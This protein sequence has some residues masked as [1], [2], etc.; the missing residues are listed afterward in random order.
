MVSPASSDRTAPMWSRMSF[1][2]KGFWPIARRPVKPLPTPITTRSG[3]TMSTNVAIADAVT[4]G[5][6]SD[7]ISTPGPSVMRDVRAP[8]SA[9]VIHTSSCSAGVS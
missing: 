1:H 9:S 2:R 7:G 5:W 8:A 4:I 3:P 6:R